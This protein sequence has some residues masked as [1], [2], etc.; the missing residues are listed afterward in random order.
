M[1]FNKEF[2]FFTLLTGILSSYLLAKYGD[3]NF[4]LTNKKIALFFSFVSLMQLVELLIWMD[5][6]CT[7]GLNK[8]AG[9]IGPLLNFSQPLLIYLLHKKTMDEN[10]F[11]KFLN[12]VYFIYIIFYYNYFINNSTICSKLLNNHIKWSWNS[13]SY[14]FYFILTIVN[15]TMIFNNKYNKIVTVIS[16]IFLFISNK[17]FK[18]NT[19]EFWCLFVTII[20]LTILII[21]KIG[22]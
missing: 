12:F 19:S 9:Y 16:A 5:I 4:K 14:I 17:Y 2:S 8:L 11:V 3:Y 15:V 1:C 13:Y 20:P 22:F 7:N 18:T 10:N 6:K 21:Q